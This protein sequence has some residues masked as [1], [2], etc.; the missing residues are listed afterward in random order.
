ML[1]G[2]LAGLSASSPGQ[3]HG[4]LMDNIGEQGRDLATCL[5]GMYRPGYSW[6]F[7]CSLYNVFGASIMVGF[8]SA[9][10]TLCGMAYGA[11]NYSKMGVLLQRALLLSTVTFII[12]IIVWNFGVEGFLRL[13]G[14]LHN[15]ALCVS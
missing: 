3:I 8:S 7:H 13:T 12:V 4:L 10:E 14:E 1:Q 6:S 15:F 9:V 2:L 11:K 5:I